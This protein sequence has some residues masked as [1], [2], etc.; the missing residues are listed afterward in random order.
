MARGTRRR[1]TASIK[2]KILLRPVR[3]GDR[4]PRRVGAQPDWNDPYQHRARLVFDDFDWE[5]DRPLEMPIEDLVIYELHVRGFT[6]HPSSGVT[7]PGTFA[8]IREKIPYLKELGVNCVELMPIFEFDEFENSRQ[9]PETGELL[10]NY[11]GY[12]TVGFFAP[13]AGYAATGRFGMQVDELKNL[14]KELHQAGIEVML[15]VVFNHTAEGN[16]RGPDDLLPRHRQPAPTT[17]S[18][19]RATTTTSAA[20]ATR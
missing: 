20:A 9:H 3:P 1:A 12:S 16:E 17:C 15:D 5:G 18:R 6:A 8:G 4:R 7:R 19:R 10:L 13:K 2:T 11:W 14:V